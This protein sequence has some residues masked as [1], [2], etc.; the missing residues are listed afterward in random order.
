MFVAIDLADKKIAKAFRFPGEIDEGFG[1]VATYKISPDGKFLFVFDDDILIYD[2]ETFKQVD[3]IALSKPPYPGASPFR[4]SVSA[5]P[6]DDPSTVTSVFVSVDPIV[7]KGLL[8]LASLNL[9]TRKVE[10]QP[11]FL[12]CLCWDS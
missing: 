4:L 7:H 3:K 11:S 6:D 12:P 1:F 9:L 5:D 8:G 2:L 10:Y